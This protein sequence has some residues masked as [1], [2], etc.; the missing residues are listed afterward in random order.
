[1]IIGKK[2]T[3]LPASVG[4]YSEKCINCHACI[5]V[6]PVKYCNDGSGE[7]VS[8]NPYMCIGCGNCIEKCTHKARYWFDDF[9]IL[10][11]DLAA[12]HEIIAIV[13]PSIA[14]NFPST[15]LHING[16]LK[17]IGVK[18]VF[19]VSFGA[20]LTVKSYVEYLNNNKEKK[21]THCTTLSG[22]CN[23]YRNVF[24]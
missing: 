9:D 10:L 19:D 6:C 7:Y 5:T 14:A 8:V 18:E 15:Y 24:T 22:D 3:E 17:S 11:E 2:L 1:M 4:V 20:E 23:V 21:N 13:A 12:G 16:W